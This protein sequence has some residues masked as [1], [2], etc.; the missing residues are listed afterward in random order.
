M[1]NE[2]RFLGHTVTWPHTAGGRVPRA[3]PGEHGLRLDQSRAGLPLRRGGRG[4]GS[5]HELQD[6]GRLL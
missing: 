5:G 3:I 4:Q 6:H 2:S 1:K